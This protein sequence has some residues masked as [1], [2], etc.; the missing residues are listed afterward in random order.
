MA[1]MS[2]KQV[3]YERLRP[4]QIAA[5]RKECPVAYLPI[6]TIEW[7]GVHNPIGLDTIKAHALA[8]R[9]A[10]VGGGLVFPPLYYGESREEGLIEANDPGREQVAEV[11][12]LP[13]ENFAPGYM[14]FSPQQQV[15]GYQR[16]LLHCLIELQSLGFKVAVLLAGHYP[17]L[18]HARAACA[19]FHQMRWDNSRAGMLTW[20]F[21]GYELVRDV[22]P[23]AGDHAGYWETSLMLAM[24]PDLVDLSEQPED[25]SAPV[26]AVH[27]YPGKPV[28]DASAE[29]GEEAI[30]LMVKRV[31][32]Q[33]K[34]RLEHPDEYYGHGWK[35]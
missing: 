10:R 8:I 2:E 5:A 3:Q 34:H 28:Q 15:E 1:G 33:V 16:L 7:H 27:S 19:T 18:D 30:Q 31:N 14:R 21:T 12:G 4:A 32:E 26:I 25:R 24:D 35:A 22:W 13:A 20:A 23:F 11:L 9:C 29:F 17:L 6:G